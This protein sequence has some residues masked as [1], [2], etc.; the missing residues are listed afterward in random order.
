MKTTLTILLIL[1]A[2]EWAIFNRVYAD[3]PYGTPPA[4]V[5]IIEKSIGYGGGTAIA[6]ASGSCVKD[7]NTG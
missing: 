5:T 2:I 7:W 1:I 3:R 6:A 4:P